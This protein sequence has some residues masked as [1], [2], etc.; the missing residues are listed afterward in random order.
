MF[1]DKITQIKADEYEYEDTEA[2]IEKGFDGYLNTD[3]ACS[4]EKLT[5][6]TSNIK[7]ADMGTDDGYDLDF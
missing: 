3:E 6:N 4:I 2:I 1:Y 7:Q 5:I